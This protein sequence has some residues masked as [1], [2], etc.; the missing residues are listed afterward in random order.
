MAADLKKIVG[1]GALVILI[2]KILR[3][4]TWK[5]KNLC[6]PQPDIIFL[7]KKL[8]PNKAQN[9]LTWNLTC[10]VTNQLIAW[11]KLF[12]IDIMCNNTYITSFSKF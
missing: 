5:K 10:I 1:K 9:K 2:K 12:Q 7:D 11:K 8:K 4:S 3:N 6:K